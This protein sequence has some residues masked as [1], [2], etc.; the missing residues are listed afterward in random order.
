MNIYGFGEVTAQ[1]IRVEWNGYSFLVIY[2]NHVNG[3]FCAIPNWKC[4]AEISHPNDTFYNKE[5]LYQVLKNKKMSEAIAEA[6]CEH[7]ET[8]TTRKA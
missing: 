4:S 7:Y 5:A 8:S 1:E 6:I 3:G 2:G